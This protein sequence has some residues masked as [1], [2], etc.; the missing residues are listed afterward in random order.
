MTIS[1]RAPGQNGSAHQWDRIAAFC[2]GV[3]FIGVMLVVAILVPT[4]TE[5]QWFIFRVVLAAA[6]AGI[7]AVI[8]GLIVVRASNYLRAGGAIALFVLIYWFNPPKLVSEPPPQ[9]RIEQSLGGVIVDQAGRPLSGVRV[10][11]PEYHKETITD[12]MGRFDLSVREAGQPM[13]KLI[14]LK[15]GYVPLHADPTLGDTSLSFA[16]QLNR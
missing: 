10:L 16:L 4:P 6:A 7:G 8:P 13:T 2:F 1:I 11:L 15:D 9:Q 5:A 12:P 3:V 14:A